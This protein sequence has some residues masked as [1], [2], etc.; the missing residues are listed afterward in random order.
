MLVNM[1]NGTEVVY[2]CTAL[3]LGKIL[4]LSNAI[5]MYF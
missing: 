2:K 5:A 1:D 4:V 3:V